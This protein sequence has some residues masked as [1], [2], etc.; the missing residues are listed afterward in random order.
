MNNKKDF[1]RFQVEPP[2]EPNPEPMVE[3]WTQV[4]INGVY[5]ALKGDPVDISWMWSPTVRVGSFM[6]IC[7][8]LRINH[9]MVRKRALECAPLGRRSTMVK[10]G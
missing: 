1:S 5:S 4:L 8:E 3:L 2:P 7:G 6:W 10:R 9:K